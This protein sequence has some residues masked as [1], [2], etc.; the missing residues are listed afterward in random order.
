MLCGM[1]R[2][3][4]IYTVRIGEVILVGCTY[5]LDKSKSHHLDRLAQ[6]RHDS[7]LLQRAYRTGSAESVS[8]Q[9]QVGAGVGSLQEQ[10]DEKLREMRCDT[11]W[12]G[13]VFTNEGDSVTI[14][15]TGSVRRVVCDEARRAMSKRMTGRKLS[16]VTRLRMSESKK[17]E[18]NGR[19]QRVTLRRGDETEEFST[20]GQASAWLGVSGESVR[21]A[22]RRG[23]ACRGWWVSVM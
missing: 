15:D 11:A 1:K 5:H 7:V 19:S 21:Q 10:A 16:D 2:E 9:T 17:G 20:M 23:S 18:R 13:L 22:A 4:G 12:A 3:A 14:D 6:G 8:F